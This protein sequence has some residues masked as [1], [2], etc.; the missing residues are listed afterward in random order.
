[1]KAAQLQEIRNREE[2]ATPGP[3]QVEDIGILLYASG[4]AQF[5]AHARQDI[6]NLLSHIDTLQDSLDHAADALHDVEC[7]EAGYWV[8]LG[9]KRATE[10]FVSWLEQNS[11]PWVAEM[12]RG[13][14]SQPARPDPPGKVRAENERLRIKMTEVIRLL[15]MHLPSSA[16]D[17]ARKSLEGE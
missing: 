3:W 10:Q 4:N 17:V 5:I 9:R 8:E 1:M 12:I 6:P 2:K 11:L 15:E 16:L 13:L 7:D 14:S